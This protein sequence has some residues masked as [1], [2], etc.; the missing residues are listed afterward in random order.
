MNERLSQL[1]VS[2][3]LIVKILIKL[4]Y[5]AAPGRRNADKGKIYRKQ[6]RSMVVRTHGSHQNGIT[7][8]QAMQCLA[9][10]DCRLAS[11]SE[12][13]APIAERKHVTLDVY[14][15]IAHHG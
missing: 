5:S 7:K 9:V 1:I 11:T 3:K 2:V 6:Y 14:R 8:K 12:A 15:A 10:Y 13:P 4:P